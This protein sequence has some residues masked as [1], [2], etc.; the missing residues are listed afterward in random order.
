MNR[1]SFE[2]V[3]YHI[4][5][6]CDFFKKGDNY[7]VHMTV[8]LT[9]FCN[10]RCVFCYGDY[11]TANPGK[12]ISADTGKFLEAFREA[13]EMGLKSISLV[14]T[15]EPL[16][17]KDA[18]KIIRGIKEIGINVAVYTNGVMVK[19]EIR[20]VILDCCTWIRLSCNAKDT[21]EHNCIHQTKGD[22]NKI[23]SNF[24]EL[25]RLRNKRGQQFPT[26]GCQFVAFQDNYLSIFDAA[27]IWKNVGIDY[28]SIKPVYKQKKNDKQPHYIK[29]YL[30]AEKIMRKTI[31][32]E[33]G[34]YKVYAKFKQFKEVL[35]QNSDRGYKQCYGNPFST[36]L[37]A[38]GNIYLCGNLHSEER[39]SFG[40][41]YNNG[42]F[43]TIWNSDRRKKVLKSIRLDECPIRC[44]NDPLNKILWNLK[45]PDPETHP[46]FL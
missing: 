35:A 2:K 45:H 44:R 36:A 28:F 13:Y 42:G 19:D 30:D 31:E 41:I 8:G 11:E 33:D 24:R 16:L 22:F 34:H 18:V 14:G 20:D 23:V 6:L 46:N 43:K 26:I 40:N 38:D 15:G 4:D 37:L 21:E 27:K 39:Y 29:N 9:T 17:H 12:N 3:F 1:L 32:L 25:V 5:Q 10:H 7:P